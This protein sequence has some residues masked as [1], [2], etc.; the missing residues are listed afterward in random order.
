[1][2]G[3][4]SILCRCWWFQISK[5]EILRSSPI[6]ICA[7]CFLLSLPV[8]G[9]GR[10]KPMDMALQG[11]MNLVQIDVRTLF[12]IIQEPV[13]VFACLFPY[14][15]FCF[16]Q[17][18]AHD[19]CLIERFPFPG[20]FL[21]S[22]QTSRM[23]QFRAFSSAH[24]FWIFPPAQ[25]PSHFSVVDRGRNP[26]IHSF[27]MLCMQ[28]RLDIYEPT[29]I[30]F[31]QSNSIPLHHIQSYSIPCTSH[32]PFMSHFL[33]H[34]SPFLMVES[35]LLVKHSIAHEILSDGLNPH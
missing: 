21:N 23:I 8:L 26:G 29:K 16:L 31:H 33:D 25:E 24:D 4:R 32:V 5:V 17:Q 11:D 6:W 34:T 28:R 2:M 27:I 22:S 3:P 35:S 10:N 12:D 15:F 18:L 20:Y 9:V 30:Q 13:D 14:A 19:M 1:M 7:N